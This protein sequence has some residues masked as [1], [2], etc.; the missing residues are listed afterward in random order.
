MIILGLTGSIGMGKTTTAKMFRDFGIPVHDADQSVHDL[1]NGKAA[2]LIE[3]AF[4]NSTRN[5][6][7]DR[8][9]LSAILAQDPARFKQLEAIIHP[10]VRDCET[11]F[12]E[13]EK[14][15][16]SP[17]VV[18]DIPLLFETAAQNRVDRVVVVS[19]DTQTQRERVFQ[20]PGMSEE[21]FNLILSR[22]IPDEEKRKRADF[23]V[24]TGRGL[25]S[26]R[27]SVEKIIDHL[28]GK[29]SDD[30]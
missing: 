22:Q 16:G 8:Q 17:L 24:D 30:A 25:E 23:V 4:P 29:I 19:C 13:R 1:Y 28:V 20:R 5:G 10:L 18:L 7:V 9:K 2:A 15:A 14:A 12:L 11:E 3:Q 26:A 6:C 27:Q 21:K